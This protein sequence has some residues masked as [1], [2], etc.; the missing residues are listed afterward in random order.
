[1]LAMAMPE[2]EAAKATVS[3]A[4]CIVRFSDTDVIMLVLVSLV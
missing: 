4:A 1:V 3:A 2:P